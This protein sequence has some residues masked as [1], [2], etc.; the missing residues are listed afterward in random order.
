MPVVTLAINT[1]IHSS[2]GCS[3]YELTFGKRP[4]LQD[5][6]LT[7]KANPYDSYAKYIQ[8]YIKEC[9]SNAVAIQTT[10]QERSK[11]YYENKRRNTLFKTGDTVAAKRP[12]RSSKLSPKYI[13]PLKVIGVKNDIYTLENTANNKTM[14]RHVSD[15]KLMQTIN[16]LMMIMCIMINNNQT[17]SLLLQDRIRPIIWLNTKSQVNLGIAEYDLHFAYTSPCPLFERNIRQGLRD[18]EDLKTDDKIQLEAFNANCKALYI[19]EW[20]HE[21]QQLI[22]VK[23]PSIPIDYRPRESKEPYDEPMRIRRSISKQHRSLHERRSITESY[24]SKERFKNEIPITI[25]NQTE[26]GRNLTSFSTTKAL[27]SLVIGPWANVFCGRSEKIKYYQQRLGDLIALRDEL[28]N[29]TSIE[30]YIK[31]IVHQGRI[32]K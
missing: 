31:R 16:L 24:Y 15:L 7:V 17:S 22:D 18:N 10:S 21:I 11:K 12:T 6:N 27:I 26:T 25:L 13:G 9:H 19:L 32:S 28:K 4:P 23:L 3:P 29:A 1:S 14:K 8:S 30:L 20:Q 2:L 5:K